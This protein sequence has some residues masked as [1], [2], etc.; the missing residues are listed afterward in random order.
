MWTKWTGWCH[1]RQ[2]D[3]LQP[4]VAH[5]A[6]FLAYC[7]HEG[8]THS[9]INTYRSALSTTIESL[10]EIRYSLGAS[11]LICRLLK[12]IYLLRPPTPR[13]SSMWDVS[14]VTTYLGT[15]V[16]LSELSLKLLTL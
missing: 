1:Q 13:Y 7:Y 5:V 11:K 16:P 6:N 8:K 2:I 3:S 12:G 15:L 9:T 14:K 4:T 10:S